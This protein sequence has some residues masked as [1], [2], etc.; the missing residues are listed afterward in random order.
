MSFKDFKL[1][2]HDFLKQHSKGET[3]NMYKNV[4]KYIAQSDTWF[5]QLH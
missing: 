2:V 5:Q 3:I 1:V 4:N